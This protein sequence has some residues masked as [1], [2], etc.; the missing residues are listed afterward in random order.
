VF[1]HEIPSAQADADLGQPVRPRLHLDVSPVAA[2]GSSEAAFGSMIIGHPEAPPTIIGS[3]EPV[4]STPLSAVRMRLPSSWTQVRSFLAEPEPTTDNDNICTDTDDGPEARRW[5]MLAHV[6]FDLRCG[7]GQQF[8]RDREAYNTAYKSSNTAQKAVF[9]KQWAKKVYE[10]I[11]SVKKKS[12][13]KSESSSNIDVSKGTCM[14]FACIVREKGNDSAGMTAA[15]NYVQAYQEMVGVWKKKN[16]MKKREE[17]LYMRQEVS[18]IFEQSCKVF[19]EHLLGTGHQTPGGPVPGNG[20]S[21]VTGSTEA[22]VDT[23]GKQKDNADK[24]K[25]KGAGPGS[26]EAVAGMEEDSHAKP[27]SA[28]WK[29][30]LFEIALEDAL[31]FCTMYRWV[32][33]K[34]ELVMKQIQTN[35]DW[36]WARDYYQGEIMKIGD[37]IKELT[38]T[39][40]AHLFLSQELQDI[41]QKYCKNDLLIHTLQFCKDFD[42]VLRRAN[43]LVNKLTK[44]QSES[45]K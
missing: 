39:G 20:G 21:A 40:F 8:T 30:N 19:E 28:D 43:K 1:E 27:K 31:D 26:T 18:D 38:T 23:V 24:P 2:T 14:P 33:S 29:R 9:R 3:S 45:M 34:I 37:P 17:F 22:A 42:C 25:A 6:G 32:W 7:A 41:N 36:K 15:I 11:C 5:V 16:Q 13:V 44:M 4:L 12:E 10:S 35:N